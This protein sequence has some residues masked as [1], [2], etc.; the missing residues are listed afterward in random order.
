MPKD[1]RTSL[2]SVVTCANSARSPASGA[3][4][5]ELEGWDVKD[6]WVRQASRTGWSVVLGGN[7]N[8]DNSADMAVG[9]GM[10]VGGVGI[11]RLAAKLT[12]D[13]DIV[14]GVGARCRVARAILRANAGASRD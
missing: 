13:V 11:V 4:R 9:V 8:R 14:R 2:V 5:S 12:G 3:A 6:G 7:D 1:A 10:P